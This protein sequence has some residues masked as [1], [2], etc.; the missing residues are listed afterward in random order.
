MQEKWIKPPLEYVQ[1]VLWREEKNNRNMPNIH[2]YSN[3][4][5]VNFKSTD[6]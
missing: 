2:D 6:L 5:I 1:C 4:L 3:S